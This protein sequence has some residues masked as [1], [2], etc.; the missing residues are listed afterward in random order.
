V[1]HLEGDLERFDHVYGSELG[2]KKSS[3]K[4]HEG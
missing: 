3:E 2:L 4:P 1:I